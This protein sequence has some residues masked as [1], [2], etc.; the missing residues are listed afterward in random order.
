MFQRAS[1]S[2]WDGVDHLAPR[3]KDGGSNDVRGKIVFGSSPLRSD[4]A[5]E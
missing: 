3:S 1:V 2:I 4:P 5:E